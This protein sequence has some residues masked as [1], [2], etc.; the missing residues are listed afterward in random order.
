MRHVDIDIKLK[1]A[2]TGPDEKNYDCWRP[3]STYRIPRFCNDTEVA[4]LY[5][6]ALAVV[7]VPTMKIMV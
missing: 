4:E 2:G 3:A 5:A 1:I 7:Y 6:D